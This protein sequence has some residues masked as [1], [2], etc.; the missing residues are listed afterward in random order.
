M[1]SLDQ[2]QQQAIAIF[3]NALA[4]CGIEQ[5]LDR[6]LHFEGKTLVRHP[7]ALLE[8]TRISLDKYKRVLILSFG[9]AGHSMLQ[10]LLARMPEGIDVRG[11]CSSPVR[12]EIRNRGFAYFTGG[13]PL[14]NKESLA[15]AREAL[16]LLRK[17]RKDTYIIFLISGGGSAILEMP[18]DKRISLE[19]TLA[20][21]ETLVAS[22]AT[23][24]EIN[25]VRKFFSAVKAG[26]LAQAAPESEKL[27]LLL[28][29]VPLKEL[30]AVASSPTLPNQATFA[31]CQ[32]VLQ[33]YRLFEQFP[34]SVRTF[35]EDLRAGKFPLPPAPDDA[36]FSN[37][38]FD[39]LL[40]NHDFVNAAR[41]HARALGYRVVI[42]NSCDDW[43]YEEASRYLLKRFQQ[44]RA[45]SPKL[46]L[47]SSGE[48]TVKLPTEHG[49]GGRNQQFALACAFALAE[50]PGKALV[51][52]SAGSDG[53]DGNSPAA[54]A[55][56][57]PT[58]L[59]RARQQ[60]FDPLAH[61]QRFDACPLFTALGD[62]IVTGP[63]GNNLR[64]LRI[65]LA[66]DTAQ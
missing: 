31:Q 45:E 1:T 8:P 24:T 27:S 17:A 66:D 56:V 64:D 2:L 51:A 4:A 13:H 40:S 18:L 60:H 35:F 50:D 30:G 5:A 37:S 7:S 29:D 44:L 6:H 26:R 41:D 20:F 53:V 55:V 28:A 43:D 54:G 52:L 11:I 42:D 10:A 25:T 59:T 3:E 62:T 63:T 22:G 14:P 47:L 61:F 49:C 12:P 16:D 9:K 19:D 38:Q 65:F 21:H 58:T 33:R 15:A 46:C 57:D 23:I 36:A 48:V 32:E 34:A 39:T